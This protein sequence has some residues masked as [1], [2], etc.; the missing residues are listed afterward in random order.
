LPERRLP[1][2]SRIVEDLL[3]DAEPAIAGTPDPVKTKY[4]LRLNR[5][6]LE[7]YASRGWAIRSIKIAKPRS[8]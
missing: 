3:K 5:E 6:L 4:L 7:L 1:D 2:G 8:G